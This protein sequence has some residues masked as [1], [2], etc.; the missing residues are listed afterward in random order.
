MPV[1]MRGFR[2]ERLLYGVGRPH[3]LVASLGGPLDFHT[4]EVREHI[5]F[6]EGDRMVNSVA[7]PKSLSIVQQHRIRARG[8][9]AH[10]APLKLFLLFAIVLFAAGCG[11]D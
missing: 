5:A 7:S 1:L 9:R 10:P 3:A 2:F 8:F 6:A 11:G 4:Y